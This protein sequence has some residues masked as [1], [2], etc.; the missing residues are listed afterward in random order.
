MPDGIR[1]PW[2]RTLRT[3][4]EIAP[5]LLQAV[6]LAMDVPAP[7]GPLPLKSFWKIEPTATL[8]GRQDTRHQSGLSR[9]PKEGWN[10]SELVLFQLTLL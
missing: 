7:E 2:I 9:R 1:P 10:H 5:H 4:S 6:G 3:T 8:T